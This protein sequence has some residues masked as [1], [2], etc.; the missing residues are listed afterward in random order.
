MPY[1]AFRNIFCRTPSPFA[2]IRRIANDDIEPAG[3]GENA[4]KIALPVEGVDAVLLLV[5]EAGSSAAPGVKIRADQRVAALDVLP[6][7][8]QGALLEQAELRAERLLALALQHLEQQRE[9]GHLHRLRV[10]VHAVDVV[11]QDALALGGGQ[12][13][14]AATAW[15]QRRGGGL[16]PFLGAVS[17]RSRRG[18][19]PAGTGTRRAGRSRSRR[20]GRGRAAAR[21]RPAPRSPGWLS[22]PAACPPCGWTMYS[23][24]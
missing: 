24:M 5:V 9:L 20:P 15:L 22:L 14:L 3:A 4:G 21:P 8:G 13:P 10:D 7:V 19:S 1:S 6:Q 23:T 17:R 18:T 16:G 12:P 11:E 2:N